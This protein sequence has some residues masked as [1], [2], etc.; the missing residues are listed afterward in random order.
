MVQGLWTLS[1]G[2]VDD[3]LRWA[4]TLYDLD[5]DGQICRDEMTRVVTAIYELMGKFAEPWLKDGTTVAAHVDFVF[6]VRLEIHNIFL[7]ETFKNQ[8]VIPFQLHW[9]YCSGRL[10]PVEFFRIVFRIHTAGR[11][12]CAYNVMQRIVFLGENRLNGCTKTCSLS[13]HIFPNFNIGSVFFR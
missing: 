10:S 11:V 4:F 5:G 7:F 9:A 13:K 12:L 3:K 6:Q 8:Y 2:S 1:R